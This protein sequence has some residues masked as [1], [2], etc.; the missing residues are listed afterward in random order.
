MEKIQVMTTE[1]WKNLVLVI[2]L[3]KIVFFDW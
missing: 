1:N 3:E 2:N